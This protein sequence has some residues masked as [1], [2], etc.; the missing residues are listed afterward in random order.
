MAAPTFAACPGVAAPVGGEK[1]PLATVVG[2][3]VFFGIRS[4]ALDFDGDP[5]A[6]G[7]RDQGQENICV[8]LAPSTGVCRGKFRTPCYTVCQ[9][10]FAKWSWAGHDVKTLPDVMCSVGLGGSGCSKPDVHFQSAPDQDWFVSET[11]LRASPETGPPPKGWKAQQAAQLNPETVQYIVVP[12]ALTKA[13]WNVSFGDVGVA[14]S[15]TT[16]DLVPFIV[17]DGGGLVEGSVSLL[18]KL[19]PAKPPKLTTVTSALGEKVQRYTSGI[20]GEF[21]FV[22]FRG[23]A[24][25]APGWGAMTAL[26]P[27]KLMGW[28]DK[29][30]RDAFGKSSNVVELTQCAALPPAPVRKR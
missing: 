8:G 30:A 26:P 14:I 6:Y 12:G 15:S 3:K 20:N 23:T 11:S 28:V 24:Q 16:G 18:A 17:G 9:E 25:R 22:V 19:S 7:V 5:H 10:T 13:P 1:G 27:S 2:G 21:R 29:T 4:L